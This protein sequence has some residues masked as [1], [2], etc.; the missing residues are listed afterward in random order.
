MDFLLEIAHKV[1]PLAAAELQVME[2][3]KRSD[4]GSGIDDRGQQVQQWDLQRYKRMV[5]MRVVGLEPADFAPY[6]SVENVM[7]GLETV[8]RETFGVF[9]S[10]VPLAK[11]EA[12]TGAYIFCAVIVQVRPAHLLAPATPPSVMQLSLTLLS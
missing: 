10:R 5:S 11:G 6:F 2:A 1:R 9:L 4:L 8:A 7:L 3:A 12:W